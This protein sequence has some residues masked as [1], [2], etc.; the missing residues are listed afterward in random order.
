MSLLSTSFSNAS[1]VN[2]FVTLPIPKQVS[3]FT[4]EL[5]STFDKPWEKLN[6]SSPYLSNTIQFNDGVS[7]HVFFQVFF[8]THLFN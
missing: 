5:F 6:M 4:I 3:V 2:I 8:Y 7:V 1:A